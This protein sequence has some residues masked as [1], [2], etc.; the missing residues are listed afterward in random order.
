[1]TL[2]DVTLRW[3]A[4][5]PGGDRIE[6]PAADDRLARSGRCRSQQRLPLP[7]GSS[8]TTLA[9]P[10]VADIEVRRTLVELEVG[11]IQIG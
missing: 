4:A 9:D 8:Y 10:A 6:L 7:N 11:R 2:V 1:M 3:H 5:L